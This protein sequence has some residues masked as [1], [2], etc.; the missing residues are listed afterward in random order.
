[1]IETD[2]L[3]KQR[4]ARLAAEALFDPIAPP[5]QTAA[6]TVVT[7][8]HRRLSSNAAEHVAAASPDAPTTAAARP[9]RTHIVAAEPAASARDT[10]AVT[11]PKVIPLDTAPLEAKSTDVQPV[12]TLAGIAEPTV[13]AGETVTAPAA[14]PVTAPTP[15]EP[16]KTRRAAT[17]TLAVN[18]QP[19]QKS[20]TNRVAIAP[21]RT[22]PKRPESKTKA[23]QDHVPSVQNLPTT[24]SFDA[25]EWPVYP[26]L[27]AQI[28][29]LKRKAQVVRERE[30]AQALEWIKGAIRQYGLSAHDLG[31]NQ[32]KL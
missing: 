15:P 6:A 7:I 23:R 13:L 20:V 18:P 26:K 5:P 14:D 8:R 32:G 31:F 27:I 29:E 25:Y 12:E 9:A 19:V 2:K 3:K 16:R 24:S 17:A 1:M 11:E 4:E 21:R 22:A 10:A 30:T 28:E